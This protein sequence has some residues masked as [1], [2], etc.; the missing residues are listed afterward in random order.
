MPPRSLT[1]SVDNPEDLSTPFGRHVNDLNL[2]GRY[3]RFILFGG[4][5]A[6]SI[7]ILI[8]TCTLLYGSVKD[9]IGE[10]RGVFMANKELVQLEVHAAQTSMRRTVINAELL[11]NGGRIARPELVEELAQRNYVIAQPNHDLVPVLAV[12][13]PPPSGAWNSERYLNI[14]EQQA[15]SF[16]AIEKQRGRPIAG[17]IYS[18]DRRFAAI[19][20][21]PAGGLGTALNRVG[22]RDVAELIERLSFDVSAMSSRQTTSRWSTTRDI[23]W[24]GPELDALTGRRVFRLVE[25][26][27]H[28]G[29]P[30]MIFVNDVSAD[31]ITHHLK[32]A[33]PDATVM[34]VDR[35]GRVVTS[36]DRT[37]ASIDGDA[38]MQRSLESGSWH[39]AFTKP[40]DSYRNGVFTV[41]D[42]IADTNWV[43][44]YSYSWRTIATALWPD[45][46]RYLGTTMLMLVTLWILLIAFDRKVFAPVYARS[47]RVFES[48]HMN[49]A[50]IATSPVGISL[51]SLES[52]DVL[53]QNAMAER[54][55][56]EHADGGNALSNA[57]LNRY[58]QNDV[59]EA[60]QLGC[61]INIRK[62]GGQTCDLLVNFVRTRYRGADALLCSFAD[63]T[64]LKSVEREIEAA[65]LAADQANRAKSMFL[66][67][68]SHEIRTPL[69]AMLGNL[70]LLE[71]AP[72]THRAQERLRSITSAS[73]GLLHTITNI[74]D[75]TKIEAGRMTLESTNF[76]MDTLVN[77]VVS[78][79][80]PS[81]AAKGIALRCHIDANVASSYYGDP[82][83][84]KQIVVNLVSN[85]L[86]FTEAGFIALEVYAAPGAQTGTPVVVQV[87]DTG[88]GIASDRLP[89]LFE[90]FV[91]ADQSIGAK[92]GGTGIGLALCKK[93]VDSMCG[94]ITLMS[95]PA[96]GSTFTV[97]LPLPSN[98]GAP[99]GEPTMDG[100]V[101]SVSTHHASNPRMLVVDDQALNRALLHDQLT[102]L[103]Y[104]ADFAAGMQE[105]LSC[106][107]SHALV[108]TDLNMPDGDG[109]TLARRLRERQPAIPIV[110]LSAHADDD[111][112]R[113]C[114][115]AGIV[116]VL[117][118][119]ISLDELGRL[120]TAYVPRAAA[121]A[122]RIAA[123]P[124]SSSKALP[125][126]LVRALTDSLDQ[127][128]RVIHEAIPHRDLRK[129]LDELHAMH[130][131]FAVAHQPELVADCIR[132]EQLARAQ[133]LSELGSAVDAFMAHAKRALS[134]NRHS[135][136]ASAQ[137]N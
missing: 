58:R 28:D 133:R 116:E 43:M 79:F 105:A 112:R 114:A 125:D 19:M 74:L 61:E 80:A 20:P 34:I 31:V 6:L 83:R 131:A 126:E 111:E 46:L 17:Y 63:I 33:P 23:E 70:E 137:T 48:E 134:D 30:F 13:S 85:A 11:W 99:D 101:N 91:Q 109:Y 8:S 42:R 49:R 96:A 45:M 89:D 55:A 69:N 22:A 54:Y 124:R 3:Q 103:G 129:I 86:K 7:V 98:H 107:D 18:P 62:A 104:T 87:R 47:Q 14:A 53:L 44:V 27:F 75:M 94:T 113:Q 136:G 117:I 10:R 9:Y 90:P 128:H 15:F 32:S 51:I 35:T 95:A 135:S 115:Q 50:I 77:E 97:T 68:M 21:A 127:M 84:I 41:S 57:L 38:L 102:V 88:M 4:G 37:H 26:A 59:G 132:L 100:G 108:I 29:R 120:L 56:T 73:R 81:V 12:G 52:D 39:R 118:K 82:L 60:A 1:V 123:V 5:I 110:A 16:T 76:R 24:H 67:T 66:A 130:G 78:M 106:F 25:P 36:E 2:L 64:E 40:D 72:D 71:K 92:F 93:L 119:P 121:S 65:R 122:H